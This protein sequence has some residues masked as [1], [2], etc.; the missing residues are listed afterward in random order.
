MQWSDDAFVMNEGQGEQMQHGSNQSCRSS[1]F[2]GQHWTRAESNA[3]D[4]GQVTVEQKA[5]SHQQRCYRVRT[6]QV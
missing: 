6:G 4:D 1:D 5:Q 3:I 2:K